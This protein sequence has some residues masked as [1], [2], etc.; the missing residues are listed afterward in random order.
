[1]Q[2]TAVGHDRIGRLS[3]LRQGD[4]A[5]SVLV[6][7]APERLDGYRPQLTA[8]YDSITGASS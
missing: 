6:L 8:L 3:I 2:G 5:L 1:V 7:A 4:H